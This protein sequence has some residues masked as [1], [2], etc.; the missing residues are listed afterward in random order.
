MYVLGTVSLSLGALALLVN[1]IL[2]DLPTTPL[3]K[4][5]EAQYQL[6]SD[7]L[8]RESDLDALINNYAYKVE[9]GKTVS[10]KTASAI[11]DAKIPETVLVESG[12][13]ANNQTTTST[14]TAPAPTTTATASTAP[15]PKCTT[16]Q[17]GVTTCI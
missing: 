17:S 11:N 12:I 16:T 7:T 1:D 15:A 5:S 13:A 8:K 6:H 14:Y 2:K 3:K 4:N 10:P 9:A